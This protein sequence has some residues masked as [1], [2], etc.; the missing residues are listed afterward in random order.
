M[1]GKCKKCG[2][3]GIL[4]QVGRIDIALVIFQCPDC[5]L[6]HSIKLCM[7][8]TNMIMD[9]EKGIYCPLEEC[10]FQKA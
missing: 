2:F 6:I 4:H 8:C 10:N 1:K 3:E 7:Q 5:C 9:S